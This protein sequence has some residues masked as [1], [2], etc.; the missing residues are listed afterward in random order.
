MNEES[1]D[2]D[3]ERFPD[4]W[5][6]ALQLDFPETPTETSWLVRNL[7]WASIS[8]VQLVGTI[9]AHT[10]GLTALCS[11]GRWVLSQGDVTNETKRSYSLVSPAVRSGVFQTHRPGETP[12][13]SS[14]LRFRTKLTE[15]SQRL[16]RH[17]NMPFMP[18]SA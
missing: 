1:S 13:K 18:V 4:R 9:V 5:E 2:L 7:S 15:W 6:V 10:T 3:L 12:Q 11:L 16:K 14:L 8:P 17:S